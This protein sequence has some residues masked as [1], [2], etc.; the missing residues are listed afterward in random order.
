MLAAVTAASVGHAPAY[1]SDAWT[2]RFADIA[3]ELFGADTEAFP[4]FNGTG[5]NVLS[6]QAALPRWGAVVCAK[7]AH[8]NVD[9]GG[10][11]EKVAGLKLL[12]VP[13]TD[14]KLTPELVDAEAWGWGDEH[15]S[16]R[17]I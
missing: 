14:G 7:S 1:G 15:L 4:V 10:A 13:T 11:P 17:H 16:L 12:S 6:L 5:A 3:R 8:I 9:E 2:A